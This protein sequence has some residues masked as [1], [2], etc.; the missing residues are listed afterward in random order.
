MTVWTDCKVVDVD[1]GVDVGEVGP[2]VRPPLLIVRQTLASSQ[3]GHSPDDRHELSVVGE[4]IGWVERFEQL[5]GD[6]E[7]D[8][9]PTS[10]ERAQ[11]PGSSTALS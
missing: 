10:N 8:G 7:R 4:R 3:R 2:R 6:R 11:H 9:Q 1:N 5:L